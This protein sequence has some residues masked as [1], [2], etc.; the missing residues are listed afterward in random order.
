MMYMYNNYLNGMDLIGAGNTR[1]MVI[2]VV[3]NGSYN[4]THL[5]NNQ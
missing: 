5:I 3:A 4:M 2:V 1:I